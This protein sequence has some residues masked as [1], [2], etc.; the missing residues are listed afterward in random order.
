[1]A[2]PQNYLEKK[3]KNS[4][5][6][7]FRG[8]FG[9]F[10]FFQVILGVGHFGSFLVIFENFSGPGDL[11]LSHWRPESQVQHAFRATKAEQSNCASSAQAAL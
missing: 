11:G 10:E 8:I 4:K 2:H 3:L 1:M 7:Y 6:M 9:I 5:K